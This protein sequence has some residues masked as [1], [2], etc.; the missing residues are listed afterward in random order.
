MSV[1]GMHVSVAAKVCHS[2]LSSNTPHTAN[3]LWGWLCDTHG[4]GSI[5]ATPSSTTVTRRINH[6]DFFTAESD[7]ATNTVVLESRLNG[8]GLPCYTRGSCSAPIT[9]TAKLK[10]VPALT[11]SLECDSGAAIVPPDAAAGLTAHRLPE[12]A[13]NAQAPRRWR[14]GGATG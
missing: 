6:T 2:H 3:H 8:T 4:V 9:G 13:W 12:E 14:R 7:D 11:T 10:L 1:A 5:C